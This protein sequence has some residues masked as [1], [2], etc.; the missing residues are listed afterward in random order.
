M[1]DRRK[2]ITMLMGL[3][4]LVAS[5][6][7]AVAPTP[8]SAA[9]L[10]VE[11]TGASG[12]FTTIQDAVDNAVAGDTIVVRRGTYFENVVVPA[13]LDGLTIRNQGATR[14]IVLD[15]DA[16]NDGIGL[17]IEADDV[18]VRGI[19][20]ENGQ[21]EGIRVASDVS[22][23]TIDRVTI[24][25]PDGD[26]VEVDGP[27]ATIKNSTLIGCGGDAINAKT[28]K[29]DGLTIERNNIRNCDDDCI[30]VSADNVTVRTT[31]IQTADDGDGIIVRG[32][33]MLI[34]SKEADYGY[35]KKVG[36]TFEIK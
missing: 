14:Q 35:L 21:V 28:G 17:S 9:T 22:G 26:C 33:Q 18:T 15:P 10:C 27:D 34:Q 1:R 7:V 24:T 16:P 19:T 29:A 36:S 5:M 12:C 20:I 6:V 4:A 30:D 11:P 31:V 8:A 2:R 3:T 23:A 32:D 25:G 13:G